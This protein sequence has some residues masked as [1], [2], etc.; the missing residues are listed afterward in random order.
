MRTRS[1]LLFGLVLVLGCGS[2]RVASVSGT[3]TLDGQPLP[4]A[5]VSFQPLSEGA[6]NPGPGSTG[7]TDEQGRYTLRVTGGGKGAVVGWHKV[8]VSCPVGGGGEDAEERRAPVRDR[9][10]P[11]YNRNSE[12]KCEVK[13][14]DNTADFPLTSK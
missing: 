4:D 11:R 14:G 3:V 2:S 6:V 5:L 1:A 12:L 9:V 13:P 10:P 7:R 8:K